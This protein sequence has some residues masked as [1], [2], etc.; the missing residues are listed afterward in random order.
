MMANRLAVLWLLF[1]LAGLILV[2]CIA[3]WGY[4]RW[5]RRYHGAPGSDGF[6]ATDE[7]FLDPT[8]GHRMTVFFNAATGQRQYRE[9][10]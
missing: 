7:T 8:T 3:V 6:T 5:D 1:E 2:V 10:G 4:F 9:H